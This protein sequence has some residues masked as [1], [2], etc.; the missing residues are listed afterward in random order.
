MS[1]TCWQHVADVSKCCH[2]SPKMHVGGDTKTP[3]TLNFCV[4]FLATLYHI[5]RSYIH[6]NTHPKNLRTHKD[7][8]PLPKKMIQL[9]WENRSNT[10]VS[11]KWS[12][13]ITPSPTTCSFITRRVFANHTSPGHFCVPSY[14]LTYR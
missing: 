13:Y 8:L 6:T 10:L 7:P 5:P 11:E 2:F 12:A 1:A 4:G 14:A 3:P 9:L